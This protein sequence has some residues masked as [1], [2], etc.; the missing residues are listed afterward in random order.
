MNLSNRDKVANFY[1]EISNF[2]LWKFGRR[3]TRHA[4]ALINNSQNVRF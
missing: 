1:I 4:D 3:A 2:L